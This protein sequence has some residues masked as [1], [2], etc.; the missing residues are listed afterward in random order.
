MVNFAVGT[1]ALL[2]AFAVSLAVRGGP[3]PLPTEAWLYS[4]GV[5]G[6]LF[7]AV[8]VVVVRLTGVLVLALAMIAGQILGALA[9]DALAPARGDAL[10]AHTLAGAALALIAV[11]VAARP[12][13]TR[14]PTPPP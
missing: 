5:L 14:V 9:L 4:G 12:I 11:L 1:A 7:I 2:A 6:V 13:P 3:E 8:F 10:T